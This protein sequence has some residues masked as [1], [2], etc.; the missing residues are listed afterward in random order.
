MTMAFNYQPLLDV[1]PMR[2]QPFRDMRVTKR[3]AG[4]QPY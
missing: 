3:L 4:L 1:I 2:T